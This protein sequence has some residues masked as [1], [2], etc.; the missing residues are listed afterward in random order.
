MPDGGSQ[1]RTEFLCEQLRLAASDKLAIRIE[2]NNSKAFY[3]RSVTGRL[4][5]TS[6]HR[7]I[8]SFEPSELTIQAR[9]GTLLAEIEAVL[10]EHRQVLAFEPPCFAD[11]GTLGGAIAS[12]LSGPAR[13]FRGA[14]RD[15]V[16]GV[17]LINGQGQLLRFGGQVMKNVAGYDV[18]RFVTGSMGTLGLFTDVSLKVLPK[19]HAQM[20]LMQQA[21]QAQAIERFTR[22]CAQPHPLSGACWHKDRLYLRL[23]GAQA[24]LKQAGSTIGGE[25]L[26]QPE[27]WWSSIRNQ[28]H[29]FFRSV[30][31][32]WR[33]SLP[34]AT[35]VAKISGDW[36]ID[37][38][39]AQR[40]LQ[41]S[42]SAAVIRKFAWDAGGH[43]TL[44][45]GGDRSGEVFHRLGEPL[46]KLHQK[47]KRSMAHSASVSARP[48]P[49]RPRRDKRNLSASRHLRS[50]LFGGSSP[51][52]RKRVG[53]DP[54]AAYQAA[55][56]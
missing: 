41:S 16:L 35:P 13:P 29:A 3:G 55:S 34:P 39:G 12:G 52:G 56:I 31:P 15:F 17:S 4:V 49:L 43:A 8:L 46:F 27:A 37:W 10:D 44:F 11:R 32:L 54:A 26:E 33:L 18:S 24:A 9:S 53:T 5:S 30:K 47:L 38:A 40:W 36:F 28:S 2:G 50:G 23:S 1:D 7:G 51:R 20:T 22:W 48:A 42:Q 19:A 25:K 14:A 45:R 21:T 6:D